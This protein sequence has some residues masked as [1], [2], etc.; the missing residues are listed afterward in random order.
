MDWI[1]GKYHTVDVYQLSVPGINRK[2]AVESN[3]QADNLCFT[4]KNNADIN[5]FL[6]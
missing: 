4:N 2:T 3:H 1:D 5:H 6:I